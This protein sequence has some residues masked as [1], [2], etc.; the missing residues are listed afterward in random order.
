MRYRK[1]RTDEDGVAIAPLG[2]LD[3]LEYTSDTTI[4]REEVAS[5]VSKVFGEVLGTDDIP[6]KVYKY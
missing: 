4:M 5:D 3:Y 2:E 1:V 6:L